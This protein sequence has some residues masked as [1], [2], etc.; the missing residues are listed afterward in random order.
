[1]RVRAAFSARHPVR[2][3]A[4]EILSA[5]SMSEVII[6]LRLAFNHSATADSVLINQDFYRSD[7]AAKIA[8]VGV[9][10]GKLC[11]SYLCIMLCR[12]WAAMTKPLLQFKQRHRLFGAYFDAS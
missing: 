10:F 4:K 3:M 11:R 1:M 6:H 12:R 2:A 5:V 9:G 8:C 7:V